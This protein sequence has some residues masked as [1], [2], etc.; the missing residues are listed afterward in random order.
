MKTP[1]VYVSRTAEQ[2]L[3]KLGLTIERSLLASIA[4]RSE[5]VVATEMTAGGVGGNERPPDPHAPQ[6]PLTEA[7]LAMV[8]EAEDRPRHAVGGRCTSC[9]PPHSTVPRRP[10]GRLESPK[11]DHNPLNLIIKRSP[12]S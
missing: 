7:V 9:Q 4:S 8:I 2:Q 11:N 12:T 10:H 1:S 6:D 3:L 5:V